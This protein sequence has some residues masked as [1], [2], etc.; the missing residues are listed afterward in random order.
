MKA[1]VSVTKNF[2]SREECQN[3]INSLD[4]WERDYIRNDTSKPDVTLNKQQLDANTEIDPEGYKI[5]QVSQSPTDYITEW[6][7]RPVYRCKVMKYEV[8]DFVEEH[9]DSLWMCQSNYWKPNTNQ[10]AKDL[11]VIPLND[12]YEGGEFT[13]NGTE[14][15]Q[16]VGSVIQFP[17]SGIPGFRPRPKHGVKKVTKGTRYSMVFW[18][19]E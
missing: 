11:M 18:N 17:Q 14:I 19:F 6:D 15:K 3:I 8:G 1:G 10:R 7:G 4:N 5:R 16:E 2:L 13:V 12:D 9:R